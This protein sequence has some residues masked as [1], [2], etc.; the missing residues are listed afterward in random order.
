ME[1]PT[2]V[3]TG[4][5]V[6]LLDRNDRVHPW[7]VDELSRLT[8]PLLTC[9]SVL[10]E[11]AFLLRKNG[12]KVDQLAQLVTA[13]IVVIDFS[14]GAQ[15]ESVRKLMRKYH[16]TPMSLADA[17]LVR[18][19]EIVPDSRVFTLDSEFFHYRRN[20]RQIIPLIHPDR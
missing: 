18:M 5:L 3:D 15:F 8:D 20:G 9:E 19:S 14:L 16:D 1:S 4:P 2:L 12:Q 17:C 7:S 6:A 10:S 11:A 13:G